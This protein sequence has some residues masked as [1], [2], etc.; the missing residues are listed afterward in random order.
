M[1]EIT[2]KPIGKVVD[3]NIVEIFEEYIPA[4][5]GVEEANYLWIFYIFHLADER[6]EVHPKGDVKRPLRGVFS[7][8][9]PYRP[10]RIGMTAVRL[11][12][13][14]NNKIFVKGLDA[15]PDSPVI[16]IKPYSEVYDL[17]YGSVLNMQ[18]ISKKI[19]DDG[20]IKDYIDLNV[21]LQPNG[22]DLTLKS[23]FRLRGDAKIDF[24]NSQRVLPEIEEIE[25][26]DDWVFLPKGFYRIG[27]NEIVK[28]SKD[29]M[30]IGRPRSTLVRGGA[31]VLTAVWDAGY[32]GRSEAGL[33]VYNE[34]GIWL[35]KNARI[36]QLVFIKLTEETKPYA[37]VYHK[38]NL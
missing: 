22:F 21:Q 11:L 1:E 24:D 25:F 36:M 26:E 14:E 17:P 23:I 18:E 31:N 20:L 28:L 2:I 33:I 13:V 19:I 35:K 16:D 5:R 38:E 34:N 10:N 7:T 4:I 32:E 3:E 6:L 27:F 8:R 15:L 30:A 37:G 9:S 29:L 12:K